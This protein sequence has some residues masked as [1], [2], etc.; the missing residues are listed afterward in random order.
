[1]VPQYIV[2]THQTESEG[3]EAMKMLMEGENSPSAIF[4]AN[5][6]TAIGA[7]KYLNSSH[8][9]KK[10]RPA[11]VSCDD[12]EEA[13]LF[14]PALTTYHLDKDEMAKHAMY[15]MSDRVSGGHKSIA[16][17]E[18]QSHLIIRESCQQPG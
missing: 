5:D 14:R 10:K 6:I 15:L 16:R 13:R 12:I 17:I 18:V 2:E 11:I 9:R 4:F 3:Y 1:M 8:I 7:L